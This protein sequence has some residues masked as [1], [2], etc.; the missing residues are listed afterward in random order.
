M[1]AVTPTTAPPQPMMRI[2]DSVLVLRDAAEARHALTVGN[3][4]EPLLAHEA[5]RD[6]VGLDAAALELLVQQMDECRSEP[7]AFLRAHWS[8]HRQLA[9]LTRNTVLSGLYVAMLDIAED[10]VM[11]VVG[12]EEHWSRSA[13]S[14]ELHRELVTAIA[15]GDPGCVTRAIRRHERFAHVER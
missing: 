8:L 7:R 5:A 15:S 13:A 6:R 1:I 14:V 4:L 10:Q 3:A 12:D 11:D 9:A 2:G